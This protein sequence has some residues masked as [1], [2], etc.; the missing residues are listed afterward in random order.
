MRCRCLVSG[1]GCCAEPESEGAG[2][3]PPE[4]VVTGSQLSAAAPAPEAGRAPASDCGWLPSRAP[5]PG[6]SWLAVSRCFVFPGPCAPDGV[7]EG[8]HLLGACLPSLRAPARGC[9]LL[10]MRLPPEAP[11]PLQLQVSSGGPW[12]LYG[13][14]GCSPVSLSGSLQVLSWGDL[15]VPSC[16][17]AHTR[18]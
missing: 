1:V 14:S 2:W 10:G 8:P 5:L 7:T 13:S 18:L 4:V 12:R 9:V 15:T 16:L 3:D 17:S 6:R 11:P